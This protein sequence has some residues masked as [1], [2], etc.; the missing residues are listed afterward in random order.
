VVYAND[1]GERIPFSIC[2]SFQEMPAPGVICG[3]AAEDEAPP[4][5]YVTA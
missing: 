5:P 3:Y 4:A 2:Y 1:P